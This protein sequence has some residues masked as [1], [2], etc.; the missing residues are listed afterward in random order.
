MRYGTDKMKDNTELLKKKINSIKDELGEKLVIL[1]H[2]Y[3]AKEIVDIGDYR[4]DS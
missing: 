2:N 4:G 3:Q 1:T